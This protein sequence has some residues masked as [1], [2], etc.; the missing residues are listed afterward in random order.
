MEMNKNLKLCPHCDGRIEIDAVSCAFCGRN[1][2]DNIRYVEE[3]VSD[4]NNSGYKRLS[5]QETLSSL[6]PPPYRPKVYE[7]DEEEETDEGEEEEIIDEDEEDT[8]NKENF[9]DKSSVITMILLS[10]GA[11][12]FF[13]SLFIMIFSSNGEL[14]L[15]WNSHWWIVYFLVSLPFIY[16]G[17]KRLVTKSS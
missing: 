3:E 12:F 5:A 10:V 7:S 16:F 2:V 13:L 15:R 4:V 1:I 9:I 11:N 14:L 8:N 17:Y 6:Y